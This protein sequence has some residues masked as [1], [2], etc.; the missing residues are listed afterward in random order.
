MKQ[1]MHRLIGLL[2]V[3]LVVNLPLSGL[4]AQTRCRPKTSSF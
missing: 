4:A 2:L 1:G 3:A